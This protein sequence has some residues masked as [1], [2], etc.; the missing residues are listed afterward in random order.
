VL[1]I[2]AHDSSTAL[3]INRSTQEG[4]D[5]ADFTATSKSGSRRK[6][7]RDCAITV[8]LKPRCYRRAFRHF[9]HLRRGGQAN[10]ACDQE[11]EPFRL[12]PLPKK[13][14]KDITGQCGNGGNFK[15]GDGKN[16]SDCPNYPPLPAHARALEFSHQEIGI[17][18]E[19][20]EA[21][22]DHRSEGIFLHG[23]DDCSVV[24]SVDGRELVRQSA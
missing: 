2:L 12:E 3:A 9:K 10:L 1:V 8:T 22:L 11:S 15:I 23:N 18:K 24:A 6:S 14:K 21:D 16:V 17:K 20:D 4:T 13:F 19:H 7:G 5:P